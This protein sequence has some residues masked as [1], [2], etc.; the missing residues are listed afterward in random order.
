MTRPKQ[1]KRSAPNDKPPAA[2]LE[3][4]GRYHDA[5]QRGHTVRIHEEDGTT[6]VQHFHI[7]EG[8][9]LLDADVREYFPDAASVNAAL[10]SLIALIPSRRPARRSRA[11]RVS[12]DAAPQP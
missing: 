7:E 1:P 4:R 8:A 12:S 6:T 11:S 3:Q 9:V 5:L 2:G 10:R